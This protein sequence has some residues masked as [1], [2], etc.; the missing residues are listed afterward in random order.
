VLHFIA[1]ST[2]LPVHNIT[3]AALH[4]QPVTAKLTLLP[5]NVLSPPPDLT[6]RHPGAW[7]PLSGRLGFAA[8]A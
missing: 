6:L 3:S 8:C 1:E 5:L 4:V 2:E 7:P